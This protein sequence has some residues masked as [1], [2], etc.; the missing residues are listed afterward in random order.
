VVD[1][2][3]PPTRK[4]YSYKIVDCRPPVPLKWMIHIFKHPDFGSEVTLCLERFPKRI[5]EQLHWKNGEE[6]VGWGIYF[7]EHI[8]VPMVLTTLFL[9]M[10]F[11]S[12]IFGT[13][14]SILEHDVSGAFTIAA[15]IT[16]IAALGL[17]VW[18][19]WLTLT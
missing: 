1:N 2:L 18:T 4:D 9:F 13:C 5:K 19:A 7:S 3:P 10:I 14:W 17:S 8:H 11:S 15:W 6:V 12:L 16:S